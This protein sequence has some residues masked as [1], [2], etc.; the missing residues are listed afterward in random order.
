MSMPSE[1][2]GK[3][4]KSGGSGGGSAKSGKSSPTPCYEYGS[5]LTTEAPP[6]IVSTPFVPQE[7][8]CEEQPWVWDGAMCVRSCD[9]TGPGSPSATACC[10]SNTGNPDCLIDDCGVVPSPSP[11]EGGTTTVGKGSDGGE[12]PQADREGVRH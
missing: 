2:Y 1:G 11:T 7:C 10:A 9:L 3:S 5:T 4:G 12:D 8:I 6:G